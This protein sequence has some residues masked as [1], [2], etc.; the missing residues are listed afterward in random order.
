[1][2]K[3]FCA[4]SVAMLCG[5]VAGTASAATIINETELVGPGNI[6]CTWT[7]PTEGAEG[8]VYIQHGYTR[9]K[10]LLDDWASHMADG[11]WDT[12]RAT[13]KLVVL[14]CDHGV[15]DGDKTW[16]G[17]VATQFCGTAPWG[18]TIPLTCNGGVLPGGGK[19]VIGGHSAGGLWAGYVAKFMHEM[20]CTTLKGVVFGDA[21]DRSG[22]SVMA[23]IVAELDKEPV[24]PI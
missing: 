14:S 18:L 3:F 1:M 2:T 4:L 12:A 5:L 22:P 11:N 13:G 8:F 7:C 17:K 9:S 16:A 19:F 6:P 15:G 20:K 23:S 21:A 10:S 24:T